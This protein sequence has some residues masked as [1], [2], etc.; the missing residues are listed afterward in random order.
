M[1]RLLLQASR[2]SAVTF[3]G[4][5]SD[6]TDCRLVNWEEMALNQYLYD[7]GE[8]VRL[9]RAPQGTGLGLSLLQRPWQAALLLRH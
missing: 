4:I 3:R 7:Q 5:V 8:V 2:D 6:T 9:F 1:K